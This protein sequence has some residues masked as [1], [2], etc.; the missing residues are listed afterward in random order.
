[1]NDAAQLSTAVAA[2]FVAAHIAHHGAVDAKGITGAFTL[3]REFLQVAQREY[4]HLWDD[5]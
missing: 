4:P 5:A 1:M 2:L 3:A